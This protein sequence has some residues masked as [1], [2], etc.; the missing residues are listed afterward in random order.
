M[1]TR[2]CHTV[3]MAP[4][5]GWYLVGPLLAVGLVTLVAAVLRYTVEHDADQLCELCTDGLAILCGQGADDDLPPDEA[6]PAGDQPADPDRAGDYGLLRAAALTDDAELAADIRQLLVD[7]GIRATH[8]V[9][10][11]RQLVVLVFGDQVEEARRLVGD[12]PL[13]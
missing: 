2:Q 4:S 13:L 1:H 12:S 3:R 7:A 6:P 8:A 11:D 9:R 10:R 5:D